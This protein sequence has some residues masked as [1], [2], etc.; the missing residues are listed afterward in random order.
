MFS[1]ETLQKHGIPVYRATHEP[2][3]FIVTFP[4]AYHG[5]FNNGFNLAEAVNFAT[6]DWLPWGQTAVESYKRCD[7]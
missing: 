4:S 2:N 1:P 5:G 7:I 6:S 3:E